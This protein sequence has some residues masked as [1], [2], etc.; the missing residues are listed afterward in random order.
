VTRTQQSLNVTPNSLPHGAKCATVHLHSAWPRRAN[1]DRLSGRARSTGVGRE[2][3]CCASSRR[4]PCRL[5]SKAAAARS[6]SPRAARM[7]KAL[8]GAEE[9]ATRTRWLVGRSLPPRR[10]RDFL[11]I[12]VLAFRSEAAPRQASDGMGDHPR[13]K[14]TTTR[15]R[16]G[17]RT[18]CLAERRRTPCVPGGRHRLRPM[19]PT[20]GFPP[21]K[22]FFLGGSP[23]TRFQVRCRWRPQRPRWSSL[24][25]SHATAVGSGA[26]PCTMRGSGTPGASGATRSCQDIGSAKPTVAAGDGRLSCIGCTCSIQKGGTAI[27]SRRG[28]R[29]GWSSASP[30]TNAEERCCRASSSG[31]LAASES[32]ARPVATPSS[33]L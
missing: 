16:M 31:A 24:T 11:I 5:S 7:D 19:A 33:C 1:N 30:T 20:Q 2:Q 17:H 13:T 10:R 28:S 14:T 26:T 12:C 18:T 9:P 6:T 25:V 32:S 27:P 21:C 3:C 22:P 29:R 15:S 4:I 8:T 23:N